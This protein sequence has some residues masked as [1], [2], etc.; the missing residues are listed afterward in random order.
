MSSAS[1]ITSATTLPQISPP[2][3]WVHHLTIDT[4]Y[5]VLQRTLL[6]PF[7]AWVL[8]LCLRAHVTPTTDVA[9]ILAVGYASVLTA[10]FVAQVVNH[11]VGHGSPRIVD[12]EREVVLVTGGASGLGLLIAQIYGM[13]GASVAVLDIK[14]IGDR[15][16][17]E[18]F[19][20]GVLYLKCDVGDRQALENAQVRIQ[21][22]LGTPTIIINCAAARINGH[23]LLELPADCFEKTMRTNLLAAFHLYQVFLPGMLCEAE[24]GGTLVTISSVVGQ[25][26][27]AG[28][29]DYS[30]SKAGLSALHRSLEAELRGNEQIKTLLVEIGQMA[31]PLFDWVRTPNH[32]FAPVLEPVE[33]AR[34]IVAAIDSGQG[35]VL[36]LPFFG[37]LVNW[38]AVFPA[39]VQIVARYLSGID[40]AVSSSLPNRAVPTDRRRVT[41]NSKKRTD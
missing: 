37:K 36:R 17:D 22:E 11:R 38:Y 1:K 18:V 32:F 19:G 7:L 30:A 31:T 26:S 20:E 16:C 40:D 9:W 4:F 21:D 14:D 13:K 41:R 29:S 3:P 6:N 15:E 10:L 33:V 39:A 25:L 5:K 27:P 2:K 34:E 28:L 8:V 23:R 12:S 24:N 35:G